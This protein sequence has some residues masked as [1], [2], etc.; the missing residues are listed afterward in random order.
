M[1]I[2]IRKG[3]S[4]NVN[5]T[6]RNSDLKGLEDEGLIS[7]SVKKSVICSRCKNVIS[8]E[9]DNIENFVTCSNCSK[10]Q[11]M[12]K[13]NSENKIS[14]IHYGKIIQKIDSLLSDMRVGYEYDKNSRYWKVKID[15]KIIPLLILEIS[16]SNYIVA[17]AENQASL[18]IMLDTEK[19]TYLIN[20]FNES[21]F[22]AFTKILEDGLLLNKALQN[23]TISFDTNHSIELEEKFD[24]L[25][26]SITPTQFE[27]FCVD[28][29][30]QI[31]INYS[32]LNTFYSYLSRFHNTILNSKIIL[33]G[34]P[35][36]PDFIMINLLRYLQSGLRPEKF[37]EAKRYGADTTFTFEKY[38]A[39]IMHGNANDTLFL[40]STTDIQLEVWKN[41]LENDRDGKFK[42]VLLDK[43]L[44]LVLI[45]CLGLENVIE[46]YLNSKNQK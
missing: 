43:P 46:K 6:S 8:L 24:K 37:G 17:N 40:V 42:Y 10:R 19:H 36:N 27:L 14:Q 3:Y 21:Q 38:S 28:L 20:Q 39:A 31:K 5:D 33:M 4:A 1:N 13:T 18:F 29:L 11:N 35:S 45:K 41:I 12:S 9:D 26:S 30:E 34:G 25:R 15:D 7:L 16:D 22:I 23:V 2:Q 44:M 32:K